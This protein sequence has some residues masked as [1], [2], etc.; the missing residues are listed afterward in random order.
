MS[1]LG[2]DYKQSY[3]NLMQHVEI[4]FKNFEVLRDFVV[5]VALLKLI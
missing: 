1:F 5:V 3:L 2:P 4:N